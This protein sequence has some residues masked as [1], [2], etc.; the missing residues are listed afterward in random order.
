MKTILLTTIIF[1]GFATYGQ[2]D[3][4]KAIK[5]VIIAF[6]KAG[7]AQDT[8]VLSDVLDESY[9]I[10]MNQLFGSKEVNV[11]SRDVFLEKIKTKEFGGDERDVS[12]G[13]IILNGNTAT[14]HVSF[15]GIKMTF[16]SLIVLVKNAEGKWKMV[17]ETPVIGA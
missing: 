11:M 4:Q 16:T 5:S 9:R 3:D 14:A 13:Q 17:S 6:S 2:K 12:I 10:V 8:K 1:L 15:K 7:D